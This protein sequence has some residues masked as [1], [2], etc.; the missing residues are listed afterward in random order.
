MGQSRDLPQRNNLIAQSVNQ[1]TPG[2]RGSA[3]TS[4]AFSAAPPVGLKK[5]GAP[6]LEHWQI[7]H[8]GFRLN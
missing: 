6:E 8:L 1:D 7:I 5:V 3:G 2:M 4:N